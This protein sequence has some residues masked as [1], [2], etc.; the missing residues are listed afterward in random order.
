VPEAEKVCWVAQQ[1]SHVFLL[2][3]WAAKLLPHLHMWHHTYSSSMM[4][5]NLEVPRTSQQ[6]ASELIEG[7]LHTR[8]G[9]RGVLLEEGSAA[10]RKKVQEAQ[11]T[12]KIVWPRQ[13]L[14]GIDMGAQ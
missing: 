3:L 8:K 11:K 14:A 7:R 12:N 5:G 4:L 2:C 9:Q 10:S 6:P 13:C 1:Q